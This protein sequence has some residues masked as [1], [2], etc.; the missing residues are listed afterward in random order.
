MKSLSTYLNESLNINE[1][2]SKI[3][4]P[5]KDITKKLK[6][7]GWI[8]DSENPDMFD[9]EFD[10]K[11]HLRIDDKSTL[12]SIKK[13]MSSM[14]YN[15]AVNKDVLMISESIDDNVNVYEIGDVI[16]IEDEDGDVVQAFIANLETSSEGINTVT[17]DVDGYITI[18]PF[19]EFLTKVQSTI[20]PLE[21]AINEN[22][23]S[24]NDLLSEFKTAG[25]KVTSK[26][27][28]FTV[29]KDNESIE[30]QKINST[31]IGYDSE[32]YDIEEFTDEMTGIIL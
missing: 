10:N 22:S 28:N 6:A 9:Y 16:N 18:I 21:D 12:N 4:L 32:K 24:F 19:T 30:F 31:T 26:G 29:V 13:F 17:Y 25:A 5:F 2:A 14:G 15:V 23:M 11:G 7:K 1:A 3:Q 20:T 8:S 27:D